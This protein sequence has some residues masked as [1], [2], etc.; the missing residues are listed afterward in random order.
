MIDPR[1]LPRGSSLEPRTN[2]AYP[3]KKVHPLAW[4]VGT[5]VAMLLIWG[6]FGMDHLKL[7]VEQSTPPA[8]A[9]L[10]VD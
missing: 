4:I 6:F 7:D 2:P 5:V 1:S 10:V 9:T 8:V 3:G